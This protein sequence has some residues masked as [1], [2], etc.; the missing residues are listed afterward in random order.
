VNPSALLD[1]LS[2]IGPRVGV[3]FDGRLHWIR[4]SA[5]EGDFIARLLQ[6]LLGEKYLVNRP[7]LQG[8]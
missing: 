8:T 1:I 3:G 7:A 5:A 2:G 4:I 6:W